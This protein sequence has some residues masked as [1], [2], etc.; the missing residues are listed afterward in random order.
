[1]LELYSLKCNNL[2]CPMGIE[3][4]IHFSWKLQSSQKSVIQ[5]SY[6]IIIW[7]N[8]EKVYDS[9]VV[10]SDQS[11]NID[12]NVRLK[13]KTLYKYDVFV[14]AVDD[15]GQE[16]QAHAR[17]E[18][19]TGLGFNGFVGEW[20][21]PP[22]NFAPDERKSAKYLRK[23]F[24]VNGIVKKAMI[25]Q[26]AHGL[27]EFYINGSLGTDEKFKPGFTSYYHRL[28]YQTYDITYLLKKGENVWS[29]VLA[30][31]WWRGVTGGT[32]TNNFGYK[33]AFVGQIEI[34]Y[35][36]GSVQIVSSDMSFKCGEGGLLASDM[37]MGEIYDAAKE[38]SSWKNSNFNDSAWQNAL[39]S[40]EVYNAKLL[41]RIVE[42]VREKETFVGNVFYD[43]ANNLVI[44]FGQNI[45]GYVKFKLRGCTKGQKITLVHGEDIK[46]GVFS[47]ANIN[48]TAFK[49]DEF[50]QV[51]YICN[52]SGEECYCPQ[53]AVFGFRY[54]KVVGYGGEIRS[55]DFT[56]IA[57]YTDVEQTG[58]FTCS[59][60]LINKLVNNS[61]WSQKGNFLDV[62]TDCPT[63][64]RNAWTGDAQIYAPTANYFAN[65]NAFYIKWLADM[66]TEQYASGKVGITAPSTSSV[67]NEKQLAILQKTFPHYALAGPAG[68][69]NFGEDCAGWGDAAA[70]IPYITY[71]FYG[72][73]KVLKEQYPMSKKWV[74]YMLKCA[75][76][77]NPLYINQPQYKNYTDGE[78][79]ADYIYDTRMHYGEWQEPIE[80]NVDLSDTASLFAKL[81]KEG[82]PKVATAYMCRSAYNVAYMAN[83]L[84]FADDAKTYKTIADKIGRVYDKYFIA[85]NGE[86]EKGH[87]AAYVRALAF[88]LC[89][90]QKRSKVLEQ[91]IEE[92]KANGYKLNTGFL[93]TP[94]LLSVLADNGYADV[95]YK[96][97]EC[98]DYP[99]WLYPVTKG[100]TTITES[101]HSVDSHEG[102]FNH[103]SYG[104]VCQFLFA[105]VGGIQPCADNAG[106]KRFII[107]PIV[108]G[109]I[110]F[111]R[112]EYESQYGKIVSEWTKENDKL[113]FY[114]EIPANT[115]A[116]MILPDGRQ[117]DLKSGKYKFKR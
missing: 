10:E 2:I 22:E 55:G 23:T 6:A 16:E 11:V 103:Y 26:T 82:K 25:Y 13:C 97:V 115:S 52:G 107:K 93:S 44:D 60:D 72:D 105:Y 100:A 112:A 76:D 91:L 74:G 73:K 39:P 57:V 59:N 46:D 17:S 67:H 42:P 80:N 70:W 31:G 85:D 65:L 27:Y 110:T 7:N 20:I 48:S 104:A 106:F 41:G 90:E 29:V 88:N 30:D 54:V 45:A 37:Q 15:N 71:L 83:E 66:R 38:P 36:N 113:S 51:T 58:R 28:Q 68:N 4:D 35:E 47:I 14:T 53:F 5:T 94:F 49:M 43:K 12:C 98:T 116:R 92:I 77:E 33:L 114:F 32:V 62:P 78:L 50:Q 21:E 24:I 86:I 95:A 64:E 18:F 87:Q 56:A 96:I 1:M 61:R 117:Q 101:W 109:T 19:F 3:G 69:G 8:D 9:G 79:D 75:K 81:I 63:R 108:G 89:S 99:S 84:G 102:S 111:A 40:T 34:E